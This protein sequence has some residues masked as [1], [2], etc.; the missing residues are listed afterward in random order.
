LS[1]FAVIPNLYKDPDLIIT[2]KIGKLL[3]DNGIKADVLSC[4]GVKDLSDYDC[5]VVLGGD[6]TILDVAK[7]AAAADVAVAGIN[8]GKIGYLASLEPENI[9]RLSAVDLTS[10]QKRMM[11][12]MEYRGKTFT[13]L[14]DIVIAE[15][16]ATRMMSLSVSADG[17]PPCE[18][19]SSAL[20]FSTPTGSSG[21]NMSAG[22]PV[23]DPG[24]ECIA[25]TPVCAHTGT[26][27]CCIY[28]SDVVF[29]AENVSSKDKSVVVS[30]DG[31]EELP[32]DI[33][34]KIIIK[35]SGFFVK[36]LQFENEPFAKTLIRKMK[37]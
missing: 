26:T 33:G 14:N 22:G 23:I 34:E 19:N 24:L 13:A 21:Y 9:E 10:Y 3:S 16:R 20:I 36:L 32:L 12:E 8:L 15:A 27:R 5:A 29:T 4:Y 30:A 28:G 1:K 37:K 11:L 31:G 18:Y 2:K 25:V 35:K 7:N 17:E 6:G